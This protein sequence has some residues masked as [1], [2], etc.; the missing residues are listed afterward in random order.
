ML[1]LLC[2]S[3]GVYVHVCAEQSIIVADTVCYAGD[4][5]WTMLQNGMAQAVQLCH[6]LAD[7]RLIIPVSASC[8]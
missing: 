4:V 2:M 8:A 3:D 7:L 5:M 1:M 6:S